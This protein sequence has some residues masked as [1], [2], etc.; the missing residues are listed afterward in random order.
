MKPIFAV[1][2]ILVLPYFIA[3]SDS[4]NARVEPS[5]DAGNEE[6]ANENVLD[7][8]AGS[9]A[10]PEKDATT[11][12]VT[13]KDASTNG[14]KALWTS[15]FG[16]GSENRAN[17]VAVDASGNILVGGY[18]QGAFTG[19]TSAGAID[20][21]LRKCD[22]SGAELWTKQFG[23]SGSEHV[24]AVSVDSSGDIVVVGGTTGTLPGEA[25]AGD[26]DAYVRKYDTAGT[27]LW[28]KQFGTS[29][30]DYAR[31][32]SVDTSG[33]IVVVGFTGAS[34]PGQTSAGSVDIFVRKYDSA[35]SLL[36]TKQFGTTGADDATAVAFDAN[37]K[38][39]VAGTV[40]SALPGQK[41]FGGADVFVRKYDSAG[42]ELWTAQFGSTMSDGVSGVTTDASGNIAISGAT[43]GA[44]PGQT[45]AGGF[46]AFARKY[47]GSGTELWTTQFGSADADYAVAVRSDTSG[48]LAVAGYTAGKLPGQKAAGGNDPF[49]RKLDGK[50]ADLWTFQFGSANRDEASSVAVDAS[51]NIVIAGFTLGALPGQSA[52]GQEDAFVAK[53]GP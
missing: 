8:S 51:G 37:G 31:A 2:S 27:V 30:A 35:G 13:A 1:V 46:D 18:T 6:D 47:D 15:Q 23:T 53:F 43:N 52:L 3:C 21:F 28:T 17:A 25:S 45:N 26:F 5:V 36:W 33:N 16:N 12:A 41:A 50:G 38:I 29:T 48:N 24:A 34:L 9:D 19:Q 32:V 49:V 7:A 39:V 20:A 10:P 11:D 22:P 4:S 44:L 42:A 14:G 40:P